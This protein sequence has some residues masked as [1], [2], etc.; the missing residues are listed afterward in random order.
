MDCSIWKLNTDS[1]QIQI[2]AQMEG[3]KSMDFIV[4]CQ[5]LEINQRKKNCYMQGEIPVP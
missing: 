5:L 2:L 4:S 1:G 3:K